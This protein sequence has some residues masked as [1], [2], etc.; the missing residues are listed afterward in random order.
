M[1]KKSSYRLQV[2]VPRKTYDEFRERYRDCLGRFVRNCLQLALSDSLFFQNVFFCDSTVFQHIKLN[3]GVK[4]DQI[5]DV[6]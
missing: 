2:I 1:I 3:D 6:F 5:N 4:N